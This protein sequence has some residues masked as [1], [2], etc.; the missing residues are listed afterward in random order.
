MY[1]FPKELIH[2]EDLQRHWFVWHR[3]VVNQK[4]IPGSDE[5]QMYII[6]HA[7]HHQNDSR[8]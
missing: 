2:T 4:K 3:S 8:F 1:A 7:L 5:K 6:Q